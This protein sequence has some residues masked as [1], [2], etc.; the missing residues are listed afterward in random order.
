MLLNSRPFVPNNIGLRK[1]TSLCISKYKEAQAAA[2]YDLSS[3]PT[4]QFSDT[5]REVLLLKYDIWFKWIIEIE[6]VLRRKQL[7]EDTR[8]IILEI[9]NALEEEYTSTVLQYKDIF[10][11]K[12]IK[13]WIKVHSFLHKYLKVKITQISIKDISKF[14]IEITDTLITVMHNTL[15]ELHEIDSLFKGNALFISFDD[16]CID[17]HKILN[18]ECLM[19]ERLGVYDRSFSDLSKDIIIKDY[20][21]SEILTTSPTNTI[22]H[23]SNEVSKYGYNVKEVI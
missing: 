8:Q 13:V 9:S 4:H 16:I 12:Y 23:I 17:Y 19:A 5:A 11:Q 21:K 1:I 3:S 15:F 2:L 14:M 6:D 20:S 22:K 7:S 10:D 18:N